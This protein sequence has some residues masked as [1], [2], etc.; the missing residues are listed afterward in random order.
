MSSLDGVDIFGSGPHA[1]RTLAW[2]RSQVRR[3]FAGVDGEMVVDLG[4]RSRRIVQ[5]GRLC[6]PTAAAMNTIIAQI[7]SLQDGQLHALIDN[8]GRT[9]AHVMVESFAL[10]GPPKCGR[11]FWCEY[12]VNYMQVP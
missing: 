5:T 10:D 9:Y 7:E 6:A 8:L 4:V 3:G 1:F 2:E 12:T 11:G